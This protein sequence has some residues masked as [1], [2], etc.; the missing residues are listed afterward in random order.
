ML[1]TTTTPLKEWEDAIWYY[2][3]VELDAKSSH[4]ICLAFIPIKAANLVL[5]LKQ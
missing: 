3:W 5:Q 2:K 4:Y 1:T